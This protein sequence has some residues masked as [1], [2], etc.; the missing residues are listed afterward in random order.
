M[1]HI[2]L[3]L[4]GTILLFSGTAVAEKGDVTLVVNLLSWH[5]DDTYCYENKCGQEYNETN[6]GL[7]AKYEFQEGFEVVGGFFDNSY[8]K[9]SVYGGMNFK[10]T[11]KFMDGILEIA[12]GLTAGFVSGYDDTP[13]R[14]QGLRPMVLP[15]IS[16]TVN[17]VQVTLGYIPGIGEDTV[18]VTTLQAGWV[19]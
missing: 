12:P 18:S 14:S 5:G 10:H 19:F 17:H 7:G 16:A 13:E 4:I 15:N 8:N 1:K 9:T 6:L 11:I 3:A 2:K